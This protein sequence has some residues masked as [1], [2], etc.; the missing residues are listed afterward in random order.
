VLPVDFDART[1]RH[2]EGPNNGILEIGCAHVRGQEQFIADD[3]PRKARGDLC[4]NRDAP[5]QNPKWLSV[6]TDHV[7]A[8]LVIGGYRAVGLGGALPIATVPYVLG[9]IPALTTR[10]LSSWRRLHLTV[11]TARQAATCATAYPS[12]I[13]R[14]SPAFGARGTPPVFSLRVNGNVHL[15]E[16]PSDMPLL[17]VLRDCLGLTGTKFGC[18]SGLGHGGTSTRYS[19]AIATPVRSCRPLHCCATSQVPPTAISRSR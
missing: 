18:G 15:V 7:A 16:A 14:T 17:W 13:Y 5:F 9:R 10:A 19:A 8:Q 11:G 1:L 6:G 4:R 2:L 3:L 12:A